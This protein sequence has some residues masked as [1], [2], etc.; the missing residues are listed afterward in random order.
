MSQGGLPVDVAETVAWLAAPT[1]AGVTGQVRPGLR[2]APG[3]GVMA[4]R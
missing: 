3:G 1:S 2:A 4:T